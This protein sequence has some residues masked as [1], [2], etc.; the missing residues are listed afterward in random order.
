M[1][2]VNYLGA[3]PTPA[4]CDYYISGHAGRPLN[5]TFESLDLPQ[6]ENCSGVDRIHIYSWARNFDGN[7][8][9][10]E[11]SVV[12]GNAKPGN[13]LSASSNALVRFI[14]QSSNSRYGGFRLKFE[15]SLN[16][17]SETIEASTGIIESPGYPVG[18]DTSRYCDW[19]ITVPKGRRVKIDVLDFNMNPHDN[20]MLKGRISLYNDLQFMSYIISIYSSTDTSKPIY[21]SDNTMG[22]A[23]VI[24]LNVGYRGFK[25]RFSSDEPTICNYNLDENVGAFETPANV[26]KFYCE[27]IRTRPFFESQP[28]VGTLSVR[29]NE[30]KRFTIRT[31]CTPNLNTGISVI[32][33]NEDKRFFYT[34]CPAKYD[35]IV[36]P[37][38]DTKIILK[39]SFYSKYRFQYKVHQCGGILTESIT[40]IV[41]PTLAQNYGELDCAWHYKSNMDRDIQMIISIPSM[42]CETEY[43]NVYRGKSSNRPR[44]AHICGDSQVSNR[45][46]GI[47]G[48]YTYIEYHVDNYTPNK[49]AFQI[50][51]V[52]SN[53][54]CGGII[55]TPNYIF[56]SP[57]NG[58]KYPANTECEW[59][60]HAES[61]Y[62]I[63]LTFINRFMIEYSPSCEKDYLKVF[64]KVDGQFIEIAKICGRE[65]PKYL[66]STGKEMKILFHTDRDGDGDGFTVKWIENCGGIFKANS[67][68]Q[69]ITSP[70]YPEPYQRNVF[71]NY[72]IIAEK[73]GEHVTVKFRTL[74]LEV[75]N[76]CV[77]DN[78]T[79]YYPTYFYRYKMREIGSYCQ[80]TSALIFRNRNRIDVI[81]RSDSFMERSGFLL[82]YN[83]DQCGGNITESTKI[84][85]IDNENGDGYIAAANCV[86]FIRAPIDQK[87]VIRFEQF[88]LEY[89]MQCLL[90]YVEVYE[91][92]HLIQSKRKARLCG[93]L[94]QHAPSVN[95]DSN[96][97]LVKFVSDETLQENGFSALV[98]FTKNCNEHINLTSTHPTHILNKLTSEYEPLLNCEYFISVP[99]G[100]VVLAKF[101]QMHL[102]PCTTTTVND[103]CTCDYLNVRDGSGPFAEPFGSFC[104]H[105]NP[106]DMQSS[107]G[108]MFMRFVTDNIDSGAGFSVQLEMI[109]S[110]C[111]PDT[112]HLNRNSSSVT[113]HSP[114]SGGVYMPNANC[115]WQISTDEDEIIEIIFDKFDLEEDPNNK[116]TADFLE[117]TEDH[118]N[119]VC[120]IRIRNSF[121]LFKKKMIFYLQDKQFIRE[122]YGANTVFSGSNSMKDQYFFWVNSMR[123][124]SFR[125]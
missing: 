46:I 19:K 39:D 89:S 87:I 53:G 36:S 67:K 5:F 51:I 84:S 75:S 35:N 113:I 60:I 59:I 13:I 28:N 97:A 1:I 98:L 54:I 100:Y 108:D 85:S 21:S 58:T 44:I 30:E 23:S 11:V 7:K 90:D 77:Y 103:S 22:I 9:L 123:F 10:N 2:F 125:M 41:L 31:P 81:F 124:R 101:K 52:S 62:H 45:S 26:T 71:C 55:N 116:C 16:E 86:W 121:V 43:L 73:E 88:E 18:Q 64:D 111:G 34:K 76:N 38:P 25:L 48:Q 65:F 78:V 122:G 63:G 68:S 82:E 79:I 27:L 95:I 120:L 118:V 110:P 47:N 96:S 70:H 109:A 119:V 33:T 20:D 80:N 72:S 102:Q 40:R 56:S 4:T 17:C 112:Y 6:A 57:K 107:A 3:Y 8:T 104:G 29:I 93:N 117:I 69:I 24:K 83:T 91:G 37:Y 92:D 49:T 66:N 99:K 114:M 15:S 50:E 115:K 61:G 74:D 94:T 106:P 14:T 105:S 42:N 32:Y 12:C